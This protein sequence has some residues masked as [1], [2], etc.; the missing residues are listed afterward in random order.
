MADGVQSPPGLP[1]VGHEHGPRA[2]HWPTTH[3]GPRDITQCQ[4]KG[5][6]HASLVAAESSLAHSHHLMSSRPLASAHRDHVVGLRRVRM[7]RLGARATRD[8]VHIRSLSAGR[9][10][11]QRRARPRPV[12]CPSSTRRPIGRCLGGGTLPENRFHAAHKELSRVQRFLM[13]GRFTPCAA[14]TRS[15]MVSA[16]TAAFG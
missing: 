1:R 14:D 12:I 6:H 10:M 4:A 8:H 2:W 11:S 13:R 3:R 5:T 16:S 9:T 15:L 7:H